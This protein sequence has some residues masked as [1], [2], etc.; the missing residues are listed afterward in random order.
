[1]SRNIRL[2][3]WAPLG[4]MVWAALPSSTILSPVCRSGRSNNKGQD[5]LSPS[6]DN[7]PQALAECL[8]QQAQI[9]VIVPLQVT[10]RAVSLRDQYRD[11]AGNRPV[12]AIRPPDHRE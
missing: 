6:S 4:W 8:L 1:M 9:T 7:S 2:S 5:C 11:A 3:P 12:T 10:L